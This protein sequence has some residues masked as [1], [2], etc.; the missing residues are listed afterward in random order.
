MSQMMPLFLM[1]RAVGGG[2]IGAEDIQGFLTGVLQGNAVLPTGPGLFNQAAQAARDV[3][4]ALF[5]AT[6][7]QMQALTSD[8]TF[9]AR[10]MLATALDDPRAAIGMYTAASGVAPGLDALLQRGLGRVYG[11][12]EAMAPGMASQN[13]DWADFLA[14]LGPYQAPAVDWNSIYNQPLPSLM[15]GR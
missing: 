6:P 7:E 13:I 1:Q 8:P 15:A 9:Q 5:G 12:Y 4:T 11:G 10:L 2:G 14:G 3:R